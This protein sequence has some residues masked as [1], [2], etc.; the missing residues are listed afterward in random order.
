MG[1]NYLLVNLYMAALVESNTINLIILAISHNN[2]IHNATGVATATA[3]GNP[4]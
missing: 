3:I 2:I 4:K 1:Y